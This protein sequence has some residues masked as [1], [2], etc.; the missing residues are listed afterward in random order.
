M[1][2]IAII[3]GVFLLFAL[4][5]NGGIGSTL[6]NISAILS[7]ISLMMFGIRSGSYK[8]INPKF[9]LS[10]FAGLTYLPIVYGRFNGRYETDWEGFK[11]DIIFLLLIVALSFKYR[12]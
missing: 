8:K 12:K 1:D 9:F 7:G 3:F 6:S 11:C 10:I 2:Y 5:F 4:M